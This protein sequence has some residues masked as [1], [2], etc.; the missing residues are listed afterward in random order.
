MILF[1]AVK[2]EYFSAI[3]KI[4][5]GMTLLEK[6]DRTF[7]PALTMVLV[8]VAHMMRMTRASIINLLASP[9][10]EMARPKRC[11]GLES[12]RQAHPAQRL[13]ASY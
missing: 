6:L 7:L 11:S 1:L 13:G 2:G 4:D 12:N 5:D 8:V 3:A 9:Y 10:V